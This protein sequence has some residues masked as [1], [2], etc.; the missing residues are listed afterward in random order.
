MALTNRQKN[1][2]NPF[3]SQFEYDW[4]N[5]RNQWVLA[6]IQDTYLNFG[7]FPEVGLEISAEPGI[8]PEG[9]S[10]KIQ[11]IQAYVS[12]YPQNA[13]VGNSSLDMLSDNEAINQLNRISSAILNIGGEEA[14][15]SPTSKEAQ[16]PENQAA[17]TGSSGVEHLIDDDLNRADVP[18]NVSEEN[19][20]KQTTSQLISIP[21]TFSISRRRKIRASFGNPITSL[22]EPTVSTV[23]DQNV[24]PFRGQS[25]TIDLYNWYNNA[26]PGEASQT[27]YYNPND[28]NYY[29]VK[30][31]NTRNKQT[32]DLGLLDSS[33]ATRNAIASAKEK[34]IEEI[35]KLVGK[36]S[37]QN[38][39]LIPRNEVEVR[40]YLNKRPSSRWVYAV[41]IPKTMI[42]G[43][44]LEDVAQNESTQDIDFEP[45]Q[46][47]ELL[48]DPDKNTSL[49]HSTF[50]L[51]GLQE[52][53]RGTIRV[54]KDYENI[55]IAE[56]ITPDVVSGFDIEREI[57]KLETFYDSLSS[58]FLYND[59]TTDDDLSNLIEFVFREDM[60][61]SY[62]IL[63]GV[64]YSKGLGATFLLPS[65]LVDEEAP[66]TSQKAVD[67]FATF[68]NRTFGFIFNSLLIDNVIGTQNQ[69][70]RPLWDEFLSTYVIPKIKISPTTQQRKRDRKDF[71][72]AKPPNIFQKIDQLTDNPPPGDLSRMAVSQKDLYYSVTSAMGSCDSVQ[73]TLLKEAF[74]IYRLIN[75]RA[76]VWSLTKYA[77]LLVRDE[78]IK[79][80]I[81]QERLN[82]GIRYAEDPSAIARDAENWVNSEISCITDLIGTAIE[83]QILKPA[84]TPKEINKLV[85]RGIVNPPLRFSFKKGF[86]SNLWSL[87]KKQIQLMLIA[88]IK[89][90][91]LGVLKDVFKAALGCG[92]DDPYN[93]AAGL[94]DSR[95]GVNYGRIMLNDLIRGID[96]VEIATDLNLTNKEVSY[97][98]D[99]D[100]RVITSPPRQDQLLQLHRDVSTIVTPTE[101]GK[102][103]DGTASEVLINTI[104]EMINAGEVDTQALFN[105]RPQIEWDDKIVV[106]MYQE[107]LSP[108]RG[109]DPPYDQPDV[110]YA[111]LGFDKDNIVNYFGEI[112]NQL[113]EGAREALYGEDPIT[114]I[115]S[116]CDDREAVPP[117]L[118]WEFDLSDV[119]K[120][121]QMEEAVNSKRLEL[122]S[123]CSMLEGK[124]NF[125]L[126]L[127]D[128]LDSIP[129]AGIYDAI[130]RWIAAL[131][132]AAVEGLMDL[133]TEDPVV[134]Q[135][136]APV[137]L[138][139]PFG[140]A[141]SQQQRQINLWD[142]PY[143]L[144][145]GITLADP[146]VD[147][148]YKTLNQGTRYSDIT[149]EDGLSPP[150]RSALDSFNEKDIYL[151]FTGDQ[152]KIVLQ[153]SG[154]QAE[155]EPDY[156]TILVRN[157][158]SERNNENGHSLT[159]DPNLLNKLPNLMD[160]NELYNTTF[161][162][163][164]EQILPASN[165]RETVY[166]IISDFYFTPLARTRLPA[167]VRSF[168][169]PYFK[170]NDDDCITTQDQAIAKTFMTSIEARVSKF[171]L[172][173][174]P[175]FR[176][177]FY[178]NTVDTIEAIS[179][180]MLNKITEDLK[181]KGLYGAYIQN[182][183][184]VLEVYGLPDQQAYSRA[185]SGLGPYNNEKILYTDDLNATEKLYEV[186]K[187]SIVLVINRQA[188]TGFPQVA[189]N[190][191]DNQV[192]YRSMGSLMLQQL[193]ENILIYLGSINPSDYTRGNPPSAPRILSFEP[194]EEQITYI[195]GPDRN[196]YNAIIA[197]EPENWY[198]HDVQYYLP[199][200]LL[201]AMHIIYFD[202]Q[203]DLTT[204]YPKY[205]Y[206]TNSRIGIADDAFLAAINPTSLPRFSVPYTGFPITALGETFYS[207]EQ[208]EDRVES[209]IIKCQIANQ[210]LARLDEILEQMED[211]KASII[212][213]MNAATEPDGIYSSA[214]RGASVSPDG[215][216]ATYAWANFQIANPY[217][218]A[219]L[220]AAWS[221]LAL[222]ALGDTDFWGTQEGADP[223]NGN[224]RYLAGYWNWIKRRIKYGGEWGSPEW[225]GFD[226]QHLLTTSY[227]DNLL[228]EPVVKWAGLGIDGGIGL[229]VGWFASQHM[230][231]DNSKERIGDLYDLILSLESEYQEYLELVRTLI[232][233]GYAQISAD[234]F[235]DT[236]I[237]LFVDP[238]Y[239][240]E[241]E[242]GGQTYTTLVPYDEENLAN[243]AK[244]KL[245]NR[246][247][248]IVQC[249][250]AEIVTE[251]LE[252]IKEQ[253]RIF[254]EARST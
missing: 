84:G 28:E 185:I 29:F 6:G 209:E 205:E 246:N 74:T 127:E 110:R 223:V 26:L 81:N 52:S 63:D 243:N 19:L 86:N 61:I 229:F 231:S 137:L 247:T 190:F 76:P 16:N 162:T 98:E 250:E 233:E 45:Y 71:R 169:A 33:E 10:I 94:A 87:W 237:D 219:A 232:K 91:I 48:I 101:L 55:M 168:I 72:I 131:S 235:R 252:N 27:Y 9:D 22:L 17:I 167:A 59:I 222:S 35:L 100:R 155:R 253:Q 234:N 213:K 49:R 161:R 67:V 118:R 221:A 203:V 108:R 194:T 163:I 172:N 224:I 197:H 13:R 7:F 113:S 18:F 175:L 218:A 120:Q 104:D 225:T 78:L 184:K 215:A 128:F 139:T 166:E 60:R 226:L 210:D 123:L 173:V 147:R 36:F 46:K 141:L 160:D 165:S 244:P 211:K 146:L 129:N 44:L 188:E 170:A 151:E 99:K 242:V 212:E 65:S 183:E 93:A 138:D 200:P 88:F 230:E 39:T 144:I 207:V 148:F 142:T 245:P 106:S 92:P 69:S 90:L 89:Q 136:R 249:E 80:K 119:Q 51:R 85:T 75:G 25:D 248:Y 11:D 180:Y 68:G 121:Q 156:R 64:L 8:I 53:I 228:D 126:E 133:F 105:E 196:N 5:V 31:T 157:T 50:T 34:G 103:L 57:L 38:F 204:R 42:D 32:Y 251:M 66:L 114:A 117:D 254:A 125:Q 95:K 37:S 62:I 240:F 107:S 124:F 189:Q 227:S 135:P 112:G 145:P 56:Q 111:V 109:A 73:S 24:I 182:V 15:T 153:L 150:P 20:L 239:E 186:I 181:S 217:G 30:R 199:V 77:A 158:L 178:W 21:Y 193:K 152:Y 174:G 130:L 83:D 4:S 132:N 134:E 192:I 2:I 198:R 208:L 54:L 41:I 154:I 216:M 236:H 102:L 195:L 97:N 12:V 23:E 116:Y 202:H 206:E 122:I 58:F 3:Y 115:Q 176:T 149:L 171:F 238:P 241:I 177:Y 96:V 40:T 214:G 187:Q 14:Y 143:P 164:Q 140:Q 82:D 201:T 1:I 43:D 159:P 70:E 220:A 191:Y 79:E 47:A 179:T